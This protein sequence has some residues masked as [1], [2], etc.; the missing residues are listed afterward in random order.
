ML[1]VGRSNLQMR[2]CYI[3][4]ELAVSG[5][6]ADLKVVKSPFPIEDVDVVVTIAAT[7]VRLSLPEDARVDEE[8]TSSIFN[9]DE[10]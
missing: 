6:A 2:I 3:Q 7:V 4:V 9:L 8:M 5:L 1:K 10:F